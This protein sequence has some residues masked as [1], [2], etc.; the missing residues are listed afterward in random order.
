MA[1]FEISLAFA[2]VA[3]RKGLDFFSAIATRI[4]ETPKGVKL[5][6]LPLKDI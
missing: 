2:S 3:G 6:P 1:C 5:R 4:S